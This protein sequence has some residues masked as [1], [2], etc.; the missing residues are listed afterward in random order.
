MGAA[1]IGRLNP[2]TQVY[3]TSGEATPS[4]KLPEKFVSTPV[5]TS[6]IGSQLDVPPDWMGERTTMPIVRRWPR[7]K[8]MRYLYARGQR[9][10]PIERVGADGIP[11]PWVS[12]FQPN[13][14]GPIRNAGFNDALFQAGYPGF[15]LGLSFKVQGIKSMNGP[16]PGMI[17]PITISQNRKV[18]TVNRTSGS[19]P[20]VK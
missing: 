6:P 17:S 10:M 19:P 14:Q 13:N 16:R 7:M 4:D 15:N 8:G 3:M 11:L 12:S 9:R 1:N 20:R 2:S 18:V 5:A